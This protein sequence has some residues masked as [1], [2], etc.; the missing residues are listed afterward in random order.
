[1]FYAD[2]DL[3]CLTWDYIQIQESELS[4]LYKLS[5]T[6]DT[7][8]WSEA[9]LVADTVAWNYCPNGLFLEK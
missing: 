8:C 7:Q 4:N 5:F 2:V 1:M 9:E 3:N 6:E